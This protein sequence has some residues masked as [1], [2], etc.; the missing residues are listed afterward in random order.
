LNQVRFAETLDQISVPVPVLDVHSPHAAD[1][2][3]HCTKVFATLTA[4]LKD[5]GN[6]ALMQIAKHY[7]EQ[8]KHYISPI[9]DLQLLGLGHGPD[10][11]FFTQFL[12]VN[13]A[14]VPSLLAELNTA[15]QNSLRDSKQFVFLTA[16][17]P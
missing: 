8:G 5:K 7:S 11:G 2:R 14:A 16:K 9:S 13:L 4:R 6:A 17:Q 10:P 12:I 15:V 3:E 1:F